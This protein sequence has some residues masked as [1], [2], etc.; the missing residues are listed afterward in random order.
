M[1]DS[2]RGVPRDFLGG[3]GVRNN[4]FLYKISGFNFY[5]EKGFSNA[6]LSVC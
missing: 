4:L 3:G 2:F 1:Q 6:F 5:F